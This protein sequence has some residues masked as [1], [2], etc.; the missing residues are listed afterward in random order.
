MNLE[1]IKLAGRAGLYLMLC[2]VALAAS[3]VALA[4]ID[5]K[6]AQGLGSAA[7]MPALM[8]GGVV[9]IVALSQAVA[10]LGVRQSL[11]T[12]VAHEI[13]VRT[14][15]T[16]LRERYDTLVVR[17]STLQGVPREAAGGEVVAWAAGHSLAELGPLESFVQDLADGTYE[18][19]SIECLQSES[20]R[21]LDLSRRQREQ[22]WIDTEE[23]ADA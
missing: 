19:D 1:I 10:A 2:C 21:V 3:T 16:A 11:E 17:G 22:G 20:E 23:K 9:M 18:G 15:A 13:P 4:F 12:D 7:V 5:N 6:L 14:L 8:L